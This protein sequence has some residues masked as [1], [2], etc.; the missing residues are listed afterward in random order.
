M[1]DIVLVIGNYKNGG[2]ARRAANLA[3]EFARRGYNCVILVTRGMSDDVYFDLHDNVKVVCLDDYIK[4][5][6]GRDRSEIA[7]RN[8]KN[9]KKL[10]HLQSVRSIFGKSNDELNF[11]IRG[12]RR[13]ERISYYIAGHVESVYI[14]FGIAMY[15]QTYFAALNSGVKL[16]YAE[17]NAPELEYPESDDERRRYMEIAAK[18]DGAVLQTLCELD[19]FGGMFNNYAVI[20]NP[21]KPGLPE[22]FT[23]DRKKTA[24]NFCR[25]AAQKNIKLM[26]DAFCLFH[27]KRPDYDMLIYGNTVEDEEE[28]YREDMISYIADKNASGFIKILPPCAD[29]HEKIADCA[30]FVSSSD[31]EGLSNSMAEAMAIGMPCVCTDCLGG[32]AREMITDGVNGVLVPMNDPQAL[33]DGMERIAGDHVFSEKISVG[34]YKIRDELSSK[35]I[36]GEWLEMINKIC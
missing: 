15:E 10:K 28:R 22:R 25:M 14:T 29:V 12:F 1:K 4:A 24:V 3:C 16:I 11:R 26:I 32:G 5:L 35:K 8:E 18:A 19:F 6:N 23:G 21:V 27:E 36:A 17:R 33:A 9:I 2:V 13:S 31:F 20:H 30:M 7:L 34:A